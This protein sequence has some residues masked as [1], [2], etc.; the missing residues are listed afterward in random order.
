[1]VAVPALGSMLMSAALR[2]KLPLELVLRLACVWNLLAAPYLP[3]A[4]VSLGELEAA[5]DAIRTSAE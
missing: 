3:N 2:E 5:S 1:M 4:S